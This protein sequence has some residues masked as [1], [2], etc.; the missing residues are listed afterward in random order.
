MKTGMIAMLAG[1]AGAL[2]T[3][4]EARGSYAGVSASLYTTVNVGGGMK[5]VYRIYANFT[6]P[7]DRLIM[8]FALSPITP[9]ITIQSMN[10]TLTGPGGNFFNPGG[11]GGNTAPAAPDGVIEWGT[12][13]TIGVSLAS[14][15]SGGSPMD[16]TTLSASFPNFIEGNSLTIA[17]VSWKVPG[18]SE[19]G[20][21]GYLGDGDPALR[22]MMMQLTVNQG[23][24]PVGSV[25]VSVQNANGQSFGLS[26]QTWTI[27]AP[28]G[29]ALLGL[30]AM[31]RKPRRG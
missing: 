20:R 29:L 25:N 11:A 6:D 3:S 24:L 31:S 22:V 10:A 28:G 5:D 18:T 23:D 14:Q 27:P 30:G 8:V 21:A 4:G 13:A 1:A 19:Q 2:A 16:E 17:N 26:G 7:N 15:G 9:P 12:F